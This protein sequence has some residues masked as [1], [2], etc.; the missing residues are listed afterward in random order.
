MKLRKLIS[1]IL[2]VALIAALAVV[3]ASADETKPVLGTIDIAGVEEICE[4][5]YGDK[6]E[7]AAYPTMNEVLAA[8]KSGRVDAAQVTEDYANYLV[9]TDDTLAYE[10]TDVSPSPLTMLTRES[11]SELTDKINGAIVELRESG[12]LDELYKTYIEDASLDNIPDAPQIENIEGADTIIVGISGDFPPHDYI[13]VDGSPAGF[14]VALIGEIAKIAGLNV[15]FETVSFGTKFAALESNRIDL[16][17][18][19]AGYTSFEGITQTEAY[20]DELYNG[21]LTVK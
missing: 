15:R 17:F 13:A 11:D 10:R 1:L 12:K 3:S 2:A 18:L 6:Y 9:L 4:A 16:F 7:V 20:D 19:H 8:L 14:N 21:I 5:L